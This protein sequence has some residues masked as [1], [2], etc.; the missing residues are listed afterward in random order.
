MVQWS[1]YSEMEDNSEQKITI[2]TWLK[3]GNWFTSK[4]WRLEEDTGFGNIRFQ[5]CVPSEGY[6]EQNWRKLNI[7]VLIW[8]ASRQIYQETTYLG[9]LGVKIHLWGT[10]VSQIFQLFLRRD[11]RSDNLGNYLGGFLNTIPARFSYISLYFLRIK[12]AVF[13]CFFLNFL[14]CLELKFFGISVMG[15]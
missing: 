7:G 12:L 14:R 8:C 2:K 6:R 13:A 4:I 5:K 1:V 10:F 15:G 3:I 11:L 9:A